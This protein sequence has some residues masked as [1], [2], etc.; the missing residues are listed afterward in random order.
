M[1]HGLLQAPSI[2]AGNAVLDYFQ[3]GVLPEPNTVCE[4]DRR[5][6]SGGDWLSIL[7]KIGV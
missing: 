4:P 2:C 1:Q 6:F 7:P 3:N 5:P